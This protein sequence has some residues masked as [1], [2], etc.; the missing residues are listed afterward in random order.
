MNILDM[1]KEEG[2]SISIYYYGKDDMASGFQIKTLID[3]HKIIKEYY[4]NNDYNVDNLDEYIDYIFI[5]SFSKLEDLL[6]IINPSIIE[7]FKNIIE[8]IKNIRSKYTKEKINNFVKNNYETILEEGGL[9]DY[10]LR[11]YEIINYTF[12]YIRDNYTGFK[13]K[14]A[15]YEYLFKKYSYKVL[16]NINKFLPVLQKYKNELGVLLTKENIELQINSKIE[17]L[18]EILKKL[19]KEGDNLYDIELYKKT[20]EIITN[21]VKERSFNPDVDSV[22]QTYTEV[23]KTTKLLEIIKDPK[24]YEFKKELEK[25]KQLLKDSL[26]KNGIQKTYEIKVND[27][28]NQIKIEKEWELRSLKMTHTRKNK[29]MSSLL[30]LSLNENKKRNVTDIANHLDLKTNDIF[31]YSVINKLEITSLVGRI[32]LQE[33][34]NIDEIVKFI[35]SGIVNFIDDNSIDIPYLDL[36]FYYLTESLNSLN[37]EIQRD[38]T[39]L[40]A[41]W[42]KSTIIYTISIIEKVLREIVISYSK[43][44][45]VLL[46]KNMTLEKIL[47]DTPIK[48]II[49]EDNVKVLQYYLCSENE[50]G[51]NLRN[52]IFHNNNNSMEICTF[53]TALQCIYLLL[54]ISNELLLKCIK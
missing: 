10:K 26:N 5:D 15:I 52:N 11:K 31:T 28:I 43:S 45:D 18:T 33:Y 41:F 7:D 48:D 14:K 30:G 42:S 17:D 38:D 12:E 51:K 20:I 49:G 27:I 44:S 25:Q 13:D 6:P 23:E 50:I 53:N 9:K 4:D 40:I 35:Y 3:K 1:F 34:G 36:D 21:I 37:K 2:E 16:Y 22:M 19:K 8:Y 54:T 46:A 39:K 32:I 47:T 29:K 24:Y